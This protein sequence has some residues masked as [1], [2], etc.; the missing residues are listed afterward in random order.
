MKE[1]VL[2]GGGDFISITSEEL[3]EMICKEMDQYVNVPQDQKIFSYIWEKVEA[4]VSK[5]KT[6]PSLKQIEN[7]IIKECEN[8]KAPFGRKDQ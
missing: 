6:M 3:K 2:I 7:L 8:F 1:Y 5:S 4:K